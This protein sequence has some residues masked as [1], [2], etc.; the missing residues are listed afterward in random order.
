MSVEEVAKSWKWVIAFQNWINALLK[1][2]NMDCKSNCC[3]SDERCVD[4]I[5]NSIQPIEHTINELADEWKKLSNHIL[6]QIKR[7]NTEL[8]ARIDW[9]NWSEETNCWKQCSDC[10]LR[11]KLECNNATLNEV[12]SQTMVLISI[13]NKI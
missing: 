11:C 7:I 6:E 9:V 1:N 13:I 5:C 4:V 12:R 3:M 8:L 10:W 2:W